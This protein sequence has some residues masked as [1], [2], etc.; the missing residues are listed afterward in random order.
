MKTALVTGGAG[1]IG[2]HLVDLLLQR[3][4]RVTILDNLEPA[5][6]PAGKPAWIPREAQFIQGDIRNVEDWRKALRGVTCVF[7]QAAWG[8]FS[9]DISKMTETN[10]SG[11]A[12][13][14][15]VIRADNL[16]VE[17]IVVASSQAVYGEGKH[18]C[19]A[20]GVC[21]PKMRS[22]AQ[23]EKGM[24]DVLCPVCGAPMKGLPI[25]EDT[26]PDVTGTYSIS[27]YAHERLTIAL[28]REFGIPTVALRYALTFGPRQS[29]FNPYTGI[30]SIFSMQILSGKRPIVFEDGKQ[31]RDFTFVQNVAEANLFVMESAKA[32]FEVFNVGTGLATPVC[33]FACT[34][35]RLY[36][37]PALEPLLPNEFRPL[38]L[39]NLFTDNTKLK[40]IGWRPNYTWQDGLAQYVTWIQSQDRPEV[41]FEKALEELRKV[42]MVKG[43]RK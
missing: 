17:K 20:H 4:Y 16:P 15:E 7:H 32:N 27:K 38:D 1:L 37:K 3:G 12:R 10:I 6:H 33:E 29:L 43:V 26:F 39:R 18:A 34:L 24:W 23:L 22:V 8:G 35:A 11:T 36:G 41:Y 40:S 14:F 42:G 28:G 30:C 25:D 9:P 31:T 2:S 21:H 13:L 19:P 5:T